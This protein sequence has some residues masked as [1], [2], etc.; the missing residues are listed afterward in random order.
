M[1][2]GRAAAGAAVAD[3]E[4]RQAARVELLGVARRVVV[5]RRAE[6]A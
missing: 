3:K 2:D 1:D 5:A 6:G 4:A